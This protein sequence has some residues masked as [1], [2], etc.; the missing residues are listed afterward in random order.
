MELRKPR[1]YVV[2]GYASNPAWSGCTFAY[3]CAT[4]DSAKKCF[5]KLSAKFAANSTDADEILLIDRED[6]KVLASVGTSS[7][8]KVAES[9]GW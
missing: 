9:F 8:K 7:P 2:K 3:A 4:L 6:H 1:R 5:D